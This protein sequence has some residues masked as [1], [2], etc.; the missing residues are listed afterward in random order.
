MSIFQNINWCRRQYSEAELESNFRQ[1]WTEGGKPGR[2][3]YLV[4]KCVVCLF[5]WSSIVYTWSQT[6]SASTYFVWITNW[7]ICLLCVTILLETFIILARFLNWNPPTTLMLVSWMTVYIFYTLAVFITI[8]YW[9]MLYD[10]SSPPSYTNLFVHGLQGVFVPLDQFIS[11][12]KWE[13]AKIWIVFP[14]PVVYLIFNVIYWAAGGMVNGVHYIYPVLDWE[15]QPGDA[16]VTVVI[17][18]F[19]LP[20]IYTMLWVVT[21]GRDRLHTTCL[22]SGRAAEE[23]NSGFTLNV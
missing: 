4:Y 3:W 22:R 16:V 6:T 18:V 5:F 23:I 11:N 21:V 15:D 20:L 9:S 19:A 7:G 12:R 10:S 1:I 17:G 8:L 13:L 14:V 2:V